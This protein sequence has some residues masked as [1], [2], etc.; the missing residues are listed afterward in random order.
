MPFYER[1][2]FFQTAYDFLKNNNYRLIHMKENE[3]EIWLEKTEKKKTNVIRLQQGGF[4][5]KNHLKRDIA[6]VFQKTKSIKNLFKGKE[7]AIHNIY[8]SAY[9]PVDDWDLLKKPLQLDEKKNP[10]RMQVYYITNESMNHE[11]TRLQNTLTLIPFTDHAQTS[12]QQA[13][14]VLDLY[15][16]YFSRLIQSAKKTNE[17]FSYGK[18]FFTYILISINLLMFL[19]QEFNGGSMEMSTLL[20]FGANYN[21][22]MVADGEWWRLIASMFLH[23]GMVHIAMNMIALYY[24]GSIVERIY[25]AKRFLL[26]YFLAGIGGGLASFLLPENIS[27]GASGAIFG[28]FGALLFFGV[29]YK[30]I[31]FRTMGKGILLIIG[32]NI[33]F[34]FSI[35]NVDMAAHLGGLVTGFI[36]SAIV[37]VPKKKHMYLQIGAVFIYLLV[38]LGMLFIGMQQ[39]KSASGFYLSQIDEML[40]VENYEM[41]VDLAT[42]GLEKTSDMEKQL[43]FQRSYANI[44]LENTEKAKKDLLKVTEMDPSNAKAYHNLASIYYGDADLTKAKEAIEKAVDLDDSASSQQLYDLIFEDEQSSA[45]KKEILVSI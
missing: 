34:G 4:D 12:E 44:H 15:R 28:L 31:F 41:V 19:L 35:P 18:P 3:K 17:V 29:V 33:I 5:W 36:A 13:N 16:Q 7:V 30:K 43:R 1:L 27:A 22:A 32:I 24:L 21:I 11:L 45:K 14:K 2:T 25:G 42:T 26:I 8:I 39:T 6:Q 20:K 9:E 38:T 37:F 40:I 10:V 23:V